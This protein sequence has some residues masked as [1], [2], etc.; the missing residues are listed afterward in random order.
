MFAIPTVLFVCTGNIY[1]SRFAEALFNH[2]AQTRDLGWCAFS[3]GLNIA[4][5]DFDGL[6]EHTQSALES[7]GI[8]LHHTATTKTALTDEDLEMAHIVIALN[9]DEHHPL[10]AKQF[11]AWADQFNYWQVGDQEL[12]E[13]AIAISLIEKETEALIAELVASSEG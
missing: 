6:S 12:C 5:T 10:V 2:P 4:T 13:P 3:R 7:R 11:P 8:E 9:H 1:R